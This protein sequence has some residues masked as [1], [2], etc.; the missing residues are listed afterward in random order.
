MLFITDPQTGQLSFKS[1]VD[2][3]MDPSGQQPW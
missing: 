1:F 3:T 2:N